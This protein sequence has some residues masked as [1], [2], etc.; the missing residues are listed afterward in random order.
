MR[1][2]DAAPPRERKHAVTS[3]TK[4]CFRTFIGQRMTGYFLK[5]GDSFLLFDDG[6]ALVIH[7][8]TGAYW[9]VGAQEVQRDL[10]AVAGELQRQT[11]DLRN[12]LD[13]AGRRS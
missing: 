12:V 1:D 4:E 2:Q 7:H 6:R 10:D 3:N 11:D 9:V 13:L 8:E 5:D